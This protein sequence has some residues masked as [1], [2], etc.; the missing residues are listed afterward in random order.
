MEKDDKSIN[1]DNSKNYSYGA[2][3]RRIIRL[4]D[5][6]PASNYNVYTDNLYGGYP[7]TTALRTRPKG[8]INTVT[9]IRKNKLSDGLSIKFVGKTP[10]PS[11][12]NSRGT[13][14][15]AQ[16]RENGIHMYGWMENGA[17][18]FID[19]TQ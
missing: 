16:Q 11:R 6:L 3:R 17:V 12:N 14:K 10:K 4:V 7:L 1:V 5:P 19:S 15:V 9:T 18:Y 8:K 2:Y 13:L